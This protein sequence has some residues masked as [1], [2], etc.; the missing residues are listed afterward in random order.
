LFAIFGDILKPKSFAGLFGA[1]P[2][3]AIATL[4]LTI[5]ADGKA[6]AALEARSMV[7]GAA[8]FGLYAYGC[9]RA[10]AQHGIR[11]ASATI[12]GL[13]VW[14]GCVLGAWFIFLR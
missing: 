10:M 3:V 2:S 6:Y 5:V 11:A 9:M 13:G 14:L 4:V 1:A 7:W 8:A 12:A